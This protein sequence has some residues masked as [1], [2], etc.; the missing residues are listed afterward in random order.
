MLGP[1]ADVLRPK[2]NE[3]HVTQLIV[4]GDGRLLTRSERAKRAPVYVRRETTSYDP[5]NKARSTNV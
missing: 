1:F 5:V 2:E 3:V 4:S